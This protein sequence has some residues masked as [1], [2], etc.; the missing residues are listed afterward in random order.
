MKERPILFDGPMVRAIL[1]GQKTQTRRVIKPQPD[2]LYRLTD[3][4]IC[5]IHNNHEQQINIEKDSNQSEQRLQSRER[6]KDLFQDAL[7]W[8]REKEIRGLVSVNW[9]QQWPGIPMCFFVPQQQE[10]DKINSSFSLHG[11][12]RNAESFNIADKAPR[13]ESAKQ[14]TREFDMGNPIRELARQENARTG[15]K[16]RETP[17]VQIIRRG[18]GT[19]S[20]R[21]SKRVLFSKTNSENLGDV[22]ICYFRNLPWNI[23]TILYVRETWGIIG[24]TCVGN[25]TQREFFSAPQLLK[26]TNEYWKSVV[27]Y[28]AS[29][30]PCVQWWP[31]IHMP[32]WA[33]R[34]W[35]RIT[36]VR[37]ER[38]QDISIKDVFNEGIQI[39]VN[40]GKPLLRL[41]GNKNNPPPTD[42]LQEDYT[43]DDFIRAYFASLWDS[44]NAKRGHYWK[45]NPWV[46]CISFE[47]IDHA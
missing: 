10:G 39:P 13:R 41:T 34:L 2:L 6:W 43:S 24:S 22:T 21:Y 20:I 40:N 3:D 44:L 23:N 1:D 46:W 19:Y 26:Y 8:L 31:S 47:R 38:V 32:K 5:A 36:N 18:A 7:C 30:D 37:V 29:G 9:P 12:S 27:K 33:A 11:F 16:W 14:Q 45:S 25:G 17:D 35:L 28:K 42:Y 4:R 15:N